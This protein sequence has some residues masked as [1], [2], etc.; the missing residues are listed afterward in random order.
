MTMIVRLVLF[1]GRFRQ[2]LCCWCVV[3]H[4]A[5]TWTS[6]KRCIHTKK[7]LKM[8]GSQVNKQSFN[9]MNAVFV[10][11]NTNITTGDLIP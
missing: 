10:N 11:G 2:I 1:N 7:L 3:F 9:E 4:A 8:W 6:I 5:L